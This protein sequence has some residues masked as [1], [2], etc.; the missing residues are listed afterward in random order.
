MAAIFFM[1]WIRLREKVSLGPLQLI[2]YE[3]GTLP[4]PIGEL[5]QLQLDGVF[6]N[7]GDR[8]HIPEGPAWVSLRRSVLVHW[9]GTSFGADVSFDEGYSRLMD[10]ELVACSA[11]SAR[12]YGSHVT[13][14]NRDE[15]K[16]IGQRFDPK[17][18]AAITVDSRRRDGERSAV[19]SYE[20]AR[21]MFMRPMHVDDGKHL[22]LD[23]G[24]LMA[25]LSARETSAWEKVRV[26]VMLF[27]AGNTDSEGG[28]DSLDL[29]LI[30]SAFEAILE[31]THSATDLEKK[32][33]AQLGL[34]AP[35]VDWPSGSISRATWHSR[36]SAKR[37]LTAWVKEFCATRNK[38]AHGKAGQPSVAPPVWSE[39]NHLMFAA[40]LFPLV[41]KTVLA[42][43]NLYVLTDH[44]R[45]CIALCEDF[46][47]EDVSF[48][49]Q[50]KA[51]LRWCEVEEKI[52]EREFDRILSQSL[53]R[54]YTNLG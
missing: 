19:M 29:I 51:R 8:S 53:T 1:P 45:D 13:Y 34:V 10:G 26:S 7:F 49:D 50:E 47:V 31:A 46:V 54:T 41:L 12:Q 5:T 4:G 44:D 33:L 39:R 15:V 38:N 42:S 52:S 27:N 14:T 24:L 6:G 22:E 2:P 11:L 48:W 21:P 30:H 25:L 28:A 17:N 37:P 35:V 40:W 3:R 32:L 43:E 23:V 36:W 16:M 18:P 9:E 20:L